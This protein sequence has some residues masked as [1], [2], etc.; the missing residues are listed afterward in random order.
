MLTF[1]VV[2]IVN[3]NTENTNSNNNRIMVDVDSNN[4]DGNDKETTIWSVLDSVYLIFDSVL[5]SRNSI[6]SGW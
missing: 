2:V 5:Y 6:L 3:D 4:S 1:E